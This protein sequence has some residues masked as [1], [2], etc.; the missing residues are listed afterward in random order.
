M[1]FKKV[2]S[3][4][5]VW[6]LANGRCVGCGAPLRGGTKKS[7]ADDQITCKCGRIYVL[8]LSTKKYRRALIAEVEA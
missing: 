4:I 1:K 8:D 6:L 5:Q 3:P 7:S 2:V